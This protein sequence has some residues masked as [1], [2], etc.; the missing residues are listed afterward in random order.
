MKKIDYAK[1]VRGSFKHFLKDPEGF[2]AKLNITL[3]E[4][5]YLNTPSRVRMVEALAMWAGMNPSSAF[6]DEVGNRMRR[7]HGFS[8]SEYY[9]ARDAHVNELLSQMTVSGTSDTN[10]YLHIVC[11]FMSL[12]NEVARKWLWHENVDFQSCESFLRRLTQAQYESLVRHYN[13]INDGVP[14]N[15]LPCFTEGVL[16]KVWGL[17]N[18]TFK[19]VGRMTTKSALAHDF[20]GMGMGFGLYPDAVDDKQ[21]NSNLASQFLSKQDRGAFEV[22]KEH[23]GLYWFLYRKLR[24]NALYHEDKEVELGRWICPGFWFTMIAWG[25]LAIASPVSLIAA[26]GL[27]ALKGV[28]STA[29]F[30][31]GA[32]LPSVAALVWARK[33]GSKAYD[34]EYWKGVFIIYV[35]LLAAFLA[36]ELIMEAKGLYSFGFGIPCFALLLPYCIKEETTKFWRAPVLGKILPLIF[37]SAGAV[38]LYTGTNFFEYCWSLMQEIGTFLYSVFMSLYKIRFVIMGWVFVLACYAA[39]IAGLLYLSDRTAKKAYVMIGKG[40][41][42]VYRYEKMINWGITAVLAVVILASINIAPR[43]NLDT[44]AMYILLAMT[45]TPFLMLLLASVTFRGVG[46]QTN[47][48]VLFR[49]LSDVSFLANERKAVKMAVA[50]N[51]FWIDVLH[52]G[53]RA[54]KLN[55]VL[56]RAHHHHGCFEWAIAI[57]R[58]VQN[59]EELSNA[60]K[61]VWED[62]DVMFYHDVTDVV[63]RLVLDGAS[64][65]VIAQ[66]AKDEDER[67]RNAQTKG[68]FFFWANLRTWSGKTLSRLL[69]FLYLLTWPVRAMW[70]GSRDLY[71]LWEVFNEQCP[72][73]PSSNKPAAR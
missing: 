36:H 46:S 55:R 50:S 12:P 63:L 54:H 7:K 31:L 40:D 58:S 16:N 15:K 44:N 59:D 67:K 64:K 11:M 42:H 6:Y 65:E 23:G 14:V 49:A 37:L 20:L 21:A 69:A 41:Q 48:W 60:V 4:R 9:V 68:N 32:I 5:K 30:S 43:F 45:A 2:A 73:A 27:L 71:H 51:A 57:I 1:A 35:C 66:A 25:I 70:K 52:A 3:V 26:V 10:E 56:Y 33:I 19:E 38:D 28:V 17:F 62:M 8:W 72:Q 34:K 22:N 53:S 61:F 47:E 39:M 18:I 13:L 29:L 24:S